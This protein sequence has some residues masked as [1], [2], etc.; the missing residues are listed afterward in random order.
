MNVHFSVSAKSIFRGSLVAIAVVAIV[1]CPRRAAVAPG[2]VAALAAT[3]GTNAIA[4]RAQPG[5]IVTVTCP[6]GGPPGS[7][8]GSD[9]Y[10]DDSSVCTAG[11]HAGR[12]NLA[13]GGTFQIQMAG[14][15]PGFMPTTRNGVTTRRYAQWPGSF[16][17]VGGATPGLVAV[18]VVTAV[19]TNPFAAM[20]AAVNATNGALQQGSQQVGQAVNQ[21]NVAMAQVAG[22]ANAWTQ[23]AVATRANLGQPTTVM[24]PPG[25][26]LGSVWGTD[27]YTDDSSVCS[28]A[29]HAGRITPAMGG[30]VTY[31]AQP[32]QAMY[33]G[34]NRNGVT[35]SNFGAFGGSFSFTP[36]VAA[37]PSG[38]PGTTT[39][40][41]TTTGTQY[42]GQSA[43]QRLWCPPGGTAGRAWGTGPYTDDSSVCSAGVHA[44]LI[45]PER[46]GVVRLH[47]MPG[48][49]RYAGALAHGVTTSSFGSFAGSFVLTR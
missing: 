34:S 17:I 29:V 46:G 33:L 18:P 40:G 19:P 31:F 44:G 15:Q 4:Y 12:V 13:T 9:I 49:P 14:P 48:L 20:Q 28:A 21:A 7:V 1:A 41:W 25:G 22:G 45:T 39:I 24:C 10:S 47:P 3:W 5:A 26:T 30:P 43:A 16:T 11:L 23:N 2:S 38:P 27:V 32:G 36:V 35:T 42:R 8:W 37:M 6:A